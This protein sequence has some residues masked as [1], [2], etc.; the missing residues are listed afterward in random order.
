MKLLVRTTFA[1]L[2]LVLAASGPLSAQQAGGIVFINSERLRAEAPGLQKAREQLQQE[3]GRFEAQADS[4]LAPLQQ[5]LQ[6]MAME[7]QQQQGMMTPETRRE[8]QQVM[9]QKQQ[10]LQQQGAQLEQRAAA[11]Q[12]EI[13]GPALERINRVIEQI[14]EDRGYAFILDVAAGGVISADPALDITDEVLRRLNAVANQG[15]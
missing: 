3:M 10:E 2:A 13:L 7:F 12:N 8:R 15:S 9:A 5:Q 4:T 14:R 1:L 6:Q 11:K